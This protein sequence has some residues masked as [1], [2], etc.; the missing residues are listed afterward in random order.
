MYYKGQGVRQD[1]ATAI[2]WYTKAA[3]QGDT[4]A[5]T[6][7]GVMYATGQGVSQNEQTA[8]AWAS[9]ACDNGEQSGCDA[10]Q[11]LNEQGY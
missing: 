2:E 8:K 5:Q 7:L 1:Y 6:I 10:Y 11:L 3:N 9:K 4:Q